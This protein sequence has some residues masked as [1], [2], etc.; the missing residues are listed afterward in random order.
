MVCAFHSGR[1]SCNAFSRYSQRT[2]VRQKMMVLGTSS[3]RS[4]MA[5]ISWKKRFFFPSSGMTMMV[6]LM[7]WLAALSFPIWMVAA[8]RRNSLARRRTCVGHVA[9]NMSVCR[10]GRT[11]SR[12]LRT[13][14]S[15]PISIIRSASS[16]TKYVTR[17]RLVVADSRKSIRRPGH[18]MQKWLPR[19]SWRFCGA[20]STPP[21]RHAFRTPA[22][23]PNFSAC[24]SICTANSRVGQRVRAIGPSSPF[25]SGW[26]RTCTMAGMRYA[27]VLP[28]PV[29]A[30]PMTSAPDMIRG[31]P[32]A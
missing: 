1:F 22:A 11:S 2:L 15:N 6:C 28:N 19:C 21:Y 8:L 24:A 27:R 4:M 14:L 13:C 26:A 30:S 31:Q 7:F 20:L 16:R 3:S 10:S 32:C 12:I 29:S 18:A 25:R 5:C 17:L 9:L 23:S